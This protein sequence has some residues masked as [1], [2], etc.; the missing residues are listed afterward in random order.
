MKVSAKLNELEI[1][2]RKEKNGAALFS[3]KAH[4]F[5]T[6]FALN[7]MAN[8]FRI[9][10]AWILR[11]GHEANQSTQNNHDKHTDQSVPQV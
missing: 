10:V 2:Q 8:Q 11:M 4:P 1:Q 3:C 6:N 5:V 9:Q 7:E